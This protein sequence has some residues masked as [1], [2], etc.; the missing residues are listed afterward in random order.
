MLQINPFLTIDDVILSEGNSPGTTNFDF[1]VTLNIVST[2]GVSVD[3]ETEDNT[4]TI[5]N[6]DYEHKSGTVTFDGNAG[7]TQTITIVVNRDDIVEDT[8]TFFVNLSNCVNCSTSDQGVGTIKDD[9]GAVSIYDVSQ[10]EGNSG[11]T[12][13]VFTLTRNGDISEEASV[14]FATVDGTATTADND[15]V[16]NFG[17][18]TFDTSSATTSVTVVVNGDETPEIAETFTV[19]L[20]NPVNITIS[21]GQGLGTIQD[22]DGSLYI[23]DVS[24]DEGNSGTT[25]FVFTLTRNGDISEEA[26]VDFATVDGTATADNDYVANS[27]TATIP[28]G[29]T[30]TTIT[31]VVN[32]DQ[33]KEDDE[34]FTVNLS[35][36]INT[37]ISD[38]QGLGTIENDD[39]SGGDNQWDTR[40]TFGVSHE[41]RNTMMVDNGFRFNDNSFALTDNH[42]TP[43]D[44]QSI[45]LGAMN[46]FAATVWADKG[47]KVQEFL[48]GVPEIGMGHL[49]EMRVEVWFDYTGEIEEVK[50]LQDSEVIDRTSLSITHQKSKCQE[51][52]V[53][54]KCDTTF[55]S[56]IFLEPLKDNVMAIKAMWI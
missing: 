34:T 47:L 44:Q 5:A 33:I 43:F 2:L 3:Y 52:D 21:D 6:D 7:E 39:K 38:N 45:E 16:A 56:A 41:T 20:D 53:E 14:D 51:K 22:D 28:A 26:S 27:G 1:T 35:N 9:D 12:D 11:T 36:P 4:A 40:P 50:V 30:T 31:V 49:A 23:D 29:S 24:L 46:S 42:H 13:F 17:T 8:E 18:A 10:F 55:M 25:D 37:M 19:N 15:Y 48:F 32:G 54:A